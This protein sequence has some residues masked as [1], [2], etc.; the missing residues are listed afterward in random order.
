MVRL[1]TTIV[2]SLIQMV[3]RMYVDIEREKPP[4]PIASLTSGLHSSACYYYLPSYHVFGCSQDSF[5]MQS[6]R[7]SHD[8]STF[9][10]GKSKVF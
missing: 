9:P 4:L 8:L 2:L 1:A 3:C 5:K 7:P 6:I 10:T